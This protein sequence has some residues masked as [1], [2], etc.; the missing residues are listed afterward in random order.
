MAEIKGLDITHVTFLEMI[1]TFIQNIGSSA[2]KGH[3]MR[4]AIVTADK[5]PPVEFESLEEFS[6]AIDELKTP[7]ARIEGKAEH[8]GN[9]LF[10]LPKCPFADTIANYKSIRGD[11]PESFS[12]VTDDFNKPSRMTEEYEIG[13]GSAVSPFCSIHQ[14]FRSALGRKITIGG[15]SV[16]IYELGCKSGGGKKAIAD[17]LIAKTDITR[18][19]VEKALDDYMC[20]YVLVQEQ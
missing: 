10:G 15:N 13:F 19:Q 14:P 4:S 11:L 7:I 17:P 16:K 5:F 20:C 12:S 9:G 18:E 8:L 2:S 3:L 6:A 1:E